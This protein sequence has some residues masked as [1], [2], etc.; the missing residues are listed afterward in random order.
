MTELEERQANAEALYDE[1]DKHPELKELVTKFLDLAEER[2]TLQRQVSR[3]YATECDSC[4]RLRNEV[5]QMM[6]VDDAE[7]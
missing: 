6:Q 3:L 4:R 1:L 7:A 2:D 5:F